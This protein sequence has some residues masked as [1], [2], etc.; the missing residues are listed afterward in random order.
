MVSGR[1]PTG[2]PPAGAA[3]SAAAGIAV[4]ILTAGYVL[5]RFGFETPL[6]PVLRAAGL[7]LFL[8]TGSEL[9]RGWSCAPEAREW[10][11]SEG[12]LG[13]CPLLIAALPGAMLPDAGWVIASIGLV[14]F[15]LALV[16]AWTGSGRVSHSAD[17][18]RLDGLL[19]RGHGVGSRLCESAFRRGARYGL[20]QSRPPW[21]RCF[22]PPSPT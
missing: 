21:I 18:S 20:P 9:L 12:W 11:A 15:A 14:S 3:V 19:A 4:L 2:A 17:C 10:F 13:F 5:A 8:T 16:R 7:G 1:E 22:T 6:Q